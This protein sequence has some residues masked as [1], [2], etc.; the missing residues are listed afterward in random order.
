MCDHIG[1]NAGPGLGA[2]C[3]VRDRSSA[4]FLPSCQMPC[5]SP[6]GPL[7]GRYPRGGSGLGVFYPVGRT[8]LQNGLQAKDAV[9][10][11]GLQ[12]VENPDPCV[13]LAEEGGTLH[14]YQ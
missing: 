6:E 5:A 9:L 4:R 11:A 1:L 8:G 7:S 3:T 14:F 10:E 13:D 2:R 12:E